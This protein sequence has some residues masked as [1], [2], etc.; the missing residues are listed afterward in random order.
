MRIQFTLLVVQRTALMDLSRQ[1]FTRKT[2]HSTEC[3]EC[4][5]SIDIYELL[6]KVTKVKCTGCGQEYSLI[7]VDDCITENLNKL[8]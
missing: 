7:D 4:T 6:H 1:V 8:Y 5:C 3:P 2:Y